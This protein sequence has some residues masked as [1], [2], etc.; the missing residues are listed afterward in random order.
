MAQTWNTR[1][2]K[3]MATSL[4]FIT[5]AST[6]KRS[7]ASS[8]DWWTALPVWRN[9]TPTVAGVFISTG[10]IIAIILGRFHCLSRS[11]LLQCL[12]R[13]ALPICRLRQCGRAAKHGQAYLPPSP[14]FPPQCNIA[15]APVDC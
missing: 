5:G 7:F 15:F 12:S 1:F 8:V 9:T 10:M 14:L 2:T 3:S 4:T 11:A 6:R 13:S